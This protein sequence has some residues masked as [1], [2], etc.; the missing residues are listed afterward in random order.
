MTTKGITSAILSKMFGID[1]RRKKFVLHLIELL[2]QLRGRINFCN[3]ARYGNHGEQY[4]RQNFSRS[5]PFD[6]LNRLLIKAYC[7]SELVIAFDPT[8]IS[9]SGK[10][11]PGI[12]YF[13][14]G[15]AQAMKRGLEVCGLA[16]L[17]IQNHTGFHYKAI[18]TEYVK[19]AESLRQCYAKMI[20]DALEGLKGLSK[21]IVFDAFFS[22][23]EFVN[24]ICGFGLTMISRMQNN[25]I[26]RYKYTGQLKGGRGRPK[27]FDG[28]IDPKNV[29]T[30]HFKVISQTNE[31]VVYEGIA[32]IKS[33][34]RWV[35][36]VILNTIKEGKVNKA[37][38]YFST[39]K[40][41]AGEK[42]LQYYKM[43][44]QIEFIY[45][46][47]KQFLGL[48]HCQ[49]RIKE[50]ISFHFNAVL[51]TLNVAKITHWLSIPKETRP[52][53]SMSDIKTK[54]SNQ[55]LMDKLITIYG[56]DPNV[57]I[58]NPLIKELYD[59]GKIAA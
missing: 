22:K 26:L 31:E 48:N 54:Y 23:K 7:G 13:W 36:V 44:F 19:G 37:F 8:Y 5:F 58:N 59:L 50:A 35:K 32:H 18:Q 10:N 57:E 16:V 40:E 14:S 29:S 1:K 43:R 41:M 15:C 39:D 27:V 52:A 4:Y 28:R 20:S 33:L 24:S 53:F 45:R 9:K 51:T 38:I 3:L 49:S 12:G 21:I 55:F 17:D 2:L 11:T 6:K 25:S 42:I 56:K 46:D 30:K 47:S 34:G